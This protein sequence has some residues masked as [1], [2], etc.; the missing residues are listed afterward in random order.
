VT[1]RA[2]LLVVD[3]DAAIRRALVGELEAA[4]YDTAT[5][6]DGEEALGRFEREPFDL[7]LTDLAM[8]RR[9][10]FSLIAGLRARSAA[11][12]IVLS[13][14]GSESDKV[15]AL[16]LGADDYVT[17][18]VAMGELLARVRTQLRRASP[19]G[20][21]LRFSDL[22]I[23]TTRRRAIQGGREVR[24][25]PRE[26]AIL[27]LLARSAG[28]PVTNPQI[29]DR[30]WGPGHAVTPDAVRVH[31]ASLRRKLEP[32]PSMPRYLVTEPWVGYRFIAEPMEEPTRPAGHLSGDPR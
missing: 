18:P 14:R 6:A 1:A 4:G 24:L 28:R 30:V 32:D 27:E 29:V 3:D 26:F 11:P 21:R 8:P 19:P 9:D 12:I 22:T 31:I 13:V 7:V 2:R 17:K 10:G 25:T 20:D 23:D 5:A 16:D 15:R